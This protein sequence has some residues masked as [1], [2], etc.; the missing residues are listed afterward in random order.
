MGQKQSLPR[1]VGSLVFFLQDP[2]DPQPGIEPGPMAVKVPNLNR[3]ITR[4]L[5]EGTVW[6]I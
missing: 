5:P 1:A 4:K 3:W 2:R 6:T